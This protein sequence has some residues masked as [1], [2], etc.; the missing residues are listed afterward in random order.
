MSAHVSASR[1]SATWYASPSPPVTSPGAAPHTRTS[2]GMLARVVNTCAGMPTSS[3]FAPSSTRTAARCREEGD[4]GT[5]VRGAAGARGLRGAVGRGLRAHGD[6]A[7]RLDEH[8]GRPRGHAL[9]GEVED[10]G[11]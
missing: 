6:A 2:Y 1:P 5:R 4:T 7:H 11:V 10:A 9:V 8:H 3:G